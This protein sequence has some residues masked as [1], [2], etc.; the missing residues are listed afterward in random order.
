MLKTAAQLATGNSNYYPYCYAYASSM[1]PIKP[2][3]TKVE[4]GEE[5]VQ[6]IPV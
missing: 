2:I 3:T 4:F 5:G 1:T 6:I